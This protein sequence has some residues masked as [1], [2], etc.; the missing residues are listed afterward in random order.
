MTLFLLPTPLGERE[1]AAYLAPA[2][3]AQVLDL[4]HFIVETPKTARRHLKTLGLNHAL[5]DL[6]FAE[7]SEHTQDADLP[8]LLAP[9]LAGES[10]ALLS[11]AGLPAIADPGARLVRLAHDRGIKVRPLVGASSIF[12]ALMSSGCEGQRFMF[13]GYLPA[14][15]H[16][17]TQALKKIENRARQDR[18]TQIFIETPYRNHAMLEAILTQLAPDLRLAVACDLTLDSEDIHSASIKNW[19]KNTMD[20]HKRPAIFLISP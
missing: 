16:A 12:L 14:E 11:D 3:I 10:A 7:L 8:E 2:E 5:Q 18:A 20:L 4:K 15:T 9:L 17:R 6:H 19:T 13:H 1:M